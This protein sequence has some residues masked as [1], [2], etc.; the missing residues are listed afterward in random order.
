MLIIDHK[1]HFTIDI[2]FNQWF[3]RNV[4]AV[5][6]L[7]D[8]TWMNKK[9]VWWIPGHLREQV[10]L[11]AANCRVGIVPHEEQAPPVTG[12]IAPLPMPEY[13][14][15]VSL[16]APAPPRSYQKQGIGRGIELQRFINGDEQGLGKTA[17]SILT[18]ATAYEQGKMSFPCLVVCPSSLKEN[19]KREWE[20]WTG[21]KAKVLTDSLKET[22][23]QYWKVGMAQVFIVN[24]ESLKKYFVLSMPAKGSLKKSSDIVMRDSINIFKSIIV[25]ESH[26]C[27]DP[28]TL[29]TK[30]TLRIAHGKPWVILCTGTPVKNRPIELYPQLAIMGR[31][32]EFGGRT[33]FLK[34][35]CEGGRGASNLSELNYL[36]NQRC[37]FRREKKDVAKDL[38]D[39]QRQQIICEITTR[40]EYQVA[41][42]HFERW[43]A[44]SGMT[45]GQI[46][47]ALRAEVLVQMNK[48]RA[49]SARGKLAEVR[50]FV[51]EVLDAGEKLILFCNL[52]EIVHALLKMFPKAVTITG[53]DSTEA[54]Q[55]N[56][57]DFQTR[58]EVQLIICN[59][60]AA[61]VGITLTASSRVA[62]V[63]FPWTY[64]DTVQCED[65][66]HRIG[67]KNSVMCTY[68]LGADTIDERMF[69]L[70]M[71]KKDIHAQVTGASD[72]MEMNTVDK[73]LNLFK[74]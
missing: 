23:P 73:M 30:L 65:R 58:P 35:Y 6:E 63:E 29:Q 24:Y 39:K 8:R 68:F 51:Q 72:Q 61:G 13:D 21:Y 43:L 55:R 28:G 70:I 56:V 53:A 33:G 38:P 25:D 18:I 36:M 5:K 1:T 45:E 60:Q 69:E 31:L 12:E 9:K 14:I 57:D 17:Q 52:K 3:K 41:K 37:Y 74:K 34:R 20:M 11:L 7:E 16:R 64:A 2:P 4:A 46:S 48:L 59:I 10:K 66:A 27:K 44:E 71:E 22:W 67:Q 54:R 40:D 47:N 42:T 62:F 19:W 26:R 32:A 49:I 15:P 50:E